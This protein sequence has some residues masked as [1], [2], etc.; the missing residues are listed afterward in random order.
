[1]DRRHEDERGHPSFSTNYGC[2][3]FAATVAAMDR[4]HEYL[5]AG[6]PTVRMNVEMNVDTLVSQ[7]ERGH[8][9][10][11]K[12]SGCSDFA[13]TVATMDRRHEYLSAGIPTVSNSL[14]L[15]IRLVISPPF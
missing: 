11:S 4:R 13:A 9:S 6:I 1:M 14:N 8:P 7:D 3:D 5:S 2:S 12:N 10:F 15:G